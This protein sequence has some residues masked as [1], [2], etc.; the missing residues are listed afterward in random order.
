VIVRLLAAACRRPHQP[1][2]RKDQEDLIN[3]Y[4]VLTGGCDEESTRLFS[5]V[6]TDRTRSNGH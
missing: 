5:V 3:G 1:G 6:P 2:G 4:E